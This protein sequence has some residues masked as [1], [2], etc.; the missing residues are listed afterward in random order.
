VLLC[1]EFGEE[2]INFWHG[3]NEGFQGR[4]EIDEAFLEGHSGES[5]Q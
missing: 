2:K 4:K 3:L 1:W 5:E